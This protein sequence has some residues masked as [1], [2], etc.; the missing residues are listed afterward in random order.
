MS[1]S[2][3]IL[4]LSSTCYY[5]RR[6][7]NCQYS[8]LQD[9]SRHVISESTSIKP[10]MMNP[11][12]VLTG[13]PMSGFIGSGVLSVKRCLSLVSQSQSVNMS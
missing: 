6:H 5:I 3:P 4:N 12:S 7:A 10:M 9:D 1:D 13:M 8:R 2:S 11:A